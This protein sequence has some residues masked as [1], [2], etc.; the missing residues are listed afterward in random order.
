MQDVFNSLTL[1]LS[2]A[3]NINNWRD[4][5]TD[6]LQ[7][8]SLALLLLPAIHTN[9]EQIRSVRESPAPRRRKHNLTTSGFHDALEPDHAILIELMHISPRVY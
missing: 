2:H 7:V 1:I 8:N 3:R 4:A 9:A 5:M 6:Q